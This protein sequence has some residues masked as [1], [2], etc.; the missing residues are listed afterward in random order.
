MVSKFQLLL[1]SADQVLLLCE[2][3]IEDL[4]HVGVVGVLSFVLGSGLEFDDGLVLILEDALQ[5]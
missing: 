4:D 1:Q 5:L 2:L 3:L